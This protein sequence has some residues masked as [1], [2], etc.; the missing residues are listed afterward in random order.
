MPR[1]PSVA[2]VKRL[3]AAGDT[4]AAEFF[5][6]TREPHVQG[7][8]SSAVVRYD[9]CIAQRHGRAQRLPVDSRCA[10]ASRTV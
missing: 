10:P 9:Q 8:F 6:G 4:F 3:T 7:G 5:G 2:L 1:L